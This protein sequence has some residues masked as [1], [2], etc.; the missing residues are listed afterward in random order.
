MYEK[1]AA[2]LLDPTD[3]CLRMARALV[4]RGI[5][6]HVLATGY[7]GFVARTRG[8]RGEL[9]PL[10]P[11]GRDAWLTRLR[12]LAAD[13]PAVVIAGS[14]WASE[15][16]TRERANLPEALR[17]FESGDGVHLKL[18]DKAS[19]YEFA[20]AAG[21]RIPWTRRVMD[22]GDLD[23]VAS[24]VDFPCIVKPLWSHSG[25]RIGDYRT[26]VAED[27]TELRELVGAALADGVP[28]LVTEHVPGGEQNLEAAVTVRLGDGSYPLV[29]GRRKVRQYPP[30]YGVGSMHRSAD[31]PDTI[32]AARRLLDMARFN[33]VAITEF[34]R[35][36]V[37]GEIVLIE[38]NVRVPRGFG[39]GDAC[40][41]DASW[42][43]YA[44]LA[45]IPLGPQP[46]PRPGIAAVL[47]EV[48]FHAVR[49][50]LRRGELTW[51][52]VLASYRGVRDL[53]VINVLDPGPAIGVVAQAAR[54]RMPGR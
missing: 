18:M 47:P 34:K 17:T 15:F 49:S 43:L 22:D 53:G 39:L 25:K 24:V 19:L 6:V 30:D 26:R 37:T 1:P 7:F 42:R 52:E 48:D 4:R 9:L 51:R 13:G 29:Y 16:L 46:T 2:I 31:V 27:E 32:E 8:A 12:E 50:R 28:M 44:S 33:G 10:L 45:G 21:V 23:P 41:A 38:V 20:E 14:D 40:G 36:A 11:E 35:H 5:H 54:A 3:G